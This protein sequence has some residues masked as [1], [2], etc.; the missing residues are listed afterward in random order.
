MTDRTVSTVID[1]ERCVGCGACVRICPSGTLS[2]VGDIAAVVGDRSLNCGH[3]AAVCPAGAVRVESIDSDAF[4]FRTFAEKG[5]W[6]PFGETDPGELVRLMRSRRSCRA[7]TAEPV[8][9]DALEDLVRAGIAAPSGTNSQVWTFSVLPDR[10]AVMR[11]GAAVGG[12]FRRLDRMASRLWLRRGLRLL[13]KPELDDYH[14]EYADSVRE[15]LDAWDRDG[16]DR[17]FH[18]ATA[19]IIVGSR[20][21]GSCP[22]EDA[23][24]ATGHILLAAHA[25]G[26]GTCLIGFAVSAMARDARVRAAAEIPP[27]EKVHAVVA[28]GHPAVEFHG[29][30]GRR[31]PTIR[32]IDGATPGG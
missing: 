22:V 8:R 20:P 25:M 1:P 28:L 4:R 19:A 2:M 13:G 27:E 29:F 30:A 5:T 14:R 31:K 10:A 18:G 16:I 3:C 26:L 12:F 9:R 21:G 32:W 7:Y 24:L 11:L 6:L 17:L 15:A 23:L